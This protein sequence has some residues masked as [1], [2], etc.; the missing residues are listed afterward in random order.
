M[1]AKLVIGVSGLA[2]LLTGSLQAADVY[3]FRGENA[4][5]KFNETGLLKQW[6]EGDSSRNGPILNWVPDGEASGS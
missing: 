2:C 4:Q 5:G 6:P 3:R 1:I